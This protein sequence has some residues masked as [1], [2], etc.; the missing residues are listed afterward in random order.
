MFLDL[1][2]SRGIHLIVERWRITALYS[3][4]EFRTEYR[5]IFHTPR[6]AWGKFLGVYRQTHMPRCFCFPRRCICTTVTR[7]QTWL[8]GNEENTDTYQNGSGAARRGTARRRRHSV[9]RRRAKKNGLDVV[10]QSASGLLVHSPWNACRLIETYGTSHYCVCVRCHHP[11]IT[12][13]LY[14]LY[15]S[16]QEDARQNLTKHV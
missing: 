5:L 3:L 13:K 2:S 14:S 16:A 15:S 9:F 4:T 6:P 7:K 10:I 11:S 8:E 12:S 1:F